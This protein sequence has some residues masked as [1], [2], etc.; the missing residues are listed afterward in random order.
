M[1][2]KICCLTLTTKHE[3]FFKE[4]L[5]YFDISTF[6]MYSNIFEKYD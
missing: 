3:W 1:S 6:T 5:V 4:L 2:L